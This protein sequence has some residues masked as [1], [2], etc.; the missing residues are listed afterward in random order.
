MAGLSNFTEHDK[1]GKVS[2][3][4]LTVVVFFPYPFSILFNRNLLFSYFLK[5]KVKGDVKNQ[6]ENHVES[7]SE[8]LMTRGSSVAQRLDIRSRTR[9]VVGSNPI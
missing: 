5:G 3:L 9:R 4:L 7:S 2:I 6:P 1:N 8:L